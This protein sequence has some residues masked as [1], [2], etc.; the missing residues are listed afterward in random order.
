MK[1]DG[2]IHTPF[3]PH[4]SADLF[5]QYIEKAIMNRFT[6]ISFTEHALLPPTFHDPTPDKDSGMVVNQLPHYIR[7]LNDLKLYYKNKI[8]IN[9][10]L[11]IDYISGYEK[12]TIAFLNEFGPQLDDAILSVHF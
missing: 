8:Q 7:Q 1:I 2:H 10:G 6:H 5:E 4:G 11:E 9:I 12:E 3:C